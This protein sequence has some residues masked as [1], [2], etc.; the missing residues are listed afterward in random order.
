[1][2]KPNRALKQNPALDFF[3]PFIG[4]WI[5]EG[6]HPYIPDV[7]LHGNCT[8][9]W[10]EGGAFV[11]SRTSMDNPQIPDGIAIFGSD[12]VTKKLFQLYF[13]ERNISRMYEVSFEENTIEWKRNTPEFS[14]QFTLT[15]SADGQT[16]TGKGMMRQNDQEWEDDIQLNYIRLK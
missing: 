10:I 13:D 5:S 8:L 15:I 16:M 9:E 14:Q 4:E 3:A 6:T 12:D 1:M 2:E 11:I 7:T